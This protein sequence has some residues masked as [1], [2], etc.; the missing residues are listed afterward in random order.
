M[1]GTN[2]ATTMY[3]SKSFE[4]RVRYKVIFLDSLPKSVAS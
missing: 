3:T 1:V 2:V 4:S